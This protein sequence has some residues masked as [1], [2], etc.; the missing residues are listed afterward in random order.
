MSWVQTY[1]VGKPCSAKSGISSWIARGL[2]DRAR[3]HVVAHLGA[4]LD[5]EHARRFDAARPRR[6]RIRW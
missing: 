4:L 6:S 1:S 2:I 3:E 5:H